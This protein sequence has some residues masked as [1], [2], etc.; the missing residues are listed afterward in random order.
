MNAGRNRARPGPARWGLATWSVLGLVFLVAPV[1]IVVP[2][3]FSAASSVQFPPT[4]FSLQWYQ[5]L[6]GDPMWSSALRTSIGLALASSI[7][8]LLLGTT[9]A[10]GLAR[11]GRR[12]RRAGLGLFFSPMLVP[13][14]VFAVALYLV[15]AKV[16]LLGTMPGLVL[17]HAVLGLPF[18]VMVMMTG[19]TALDPSLEL[20]AASLGARPVQVWA[21]VLTPTLLPHLLVSWLFAFIVSFDEVVLTIFVSGAYETVPKKMFI[22]LRNEIDPTIT[23]VSTLLI[24]VTIL[25]GIAAAV[26]LRRRLLTVLGASNSQ[27]PTEG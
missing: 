6:L 16:G 12:S 25:A 14:V 5:R 22:S 18:V 24:A 19:I 27:P 26:L 23:A 10:Y 20:A 11:A 4:G 1:V 13:G 15:Y 3:S 9:G 2:M 21:R 17:A 7:T 8:A